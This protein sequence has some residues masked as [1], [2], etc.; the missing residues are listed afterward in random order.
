MNRIIIGLIFSL[1]F[2]A[3]AVEVTF[4]N[5]SYKGSPFWQQVSEIANAAASDLNISLNIIYSSGHR[6]LQKEQINQLIAQ[7][8]KPDY[9]VFLPYDGTA[10]ATFN[11]LE[12]AK[13]PFITLERSLF[14]DLQDKLGK[15]GQPF[16]YWLAEI[17]HD[18]KKAGALLAKA[19][20]KTSR[21]TLSNRVDLT[22]VGISGDISGHSNERN[23]GLIAEL[24]QAPEFTLTQIVN[25]RWER[26]Q[27]GKVFIG[28]LRRY[29]DIQLVWSASDTWGS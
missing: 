19:L 25:A 11:K 15:P 1:A 4:I 5:P 28:L 12:L 24:N 9:V 6:L 10:M 18:N 27:A 29:Q 17:Y 3:Q 23:A 21:E 7:E 13:I 8:N 26:E 20:I 14:P 22:A 16:K 2:S